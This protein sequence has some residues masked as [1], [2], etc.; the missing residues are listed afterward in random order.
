MPAYV[1]YGRA[2]PIYRK[3]TLSGD[4]GSQQ[5]ISKT[6]G[7]FVDPSGLYEIELTEETIASR[8]AI[9]PLHFRG[10]T[11]RT[12]LVAQTETIRTV[13]S[14]EETVTMT[15]SNLYSTDDLQEAVQDSLDA[16]ATANA[17]ASGIDPDGLAFVHFLSPDETY[18]KRKI[19]VSI[20]IFVGG[21]SLTSVPS[22]PT[23]LFVTPGG[24]VTV[25]VRWR[26]RTVLLTTG[27]V[28]TSLQSTTATLTASPGYEV[29]LKQGLPAP[30]PTPITLTFTA[31]ENTAI[32]IDQVSVDPSPLVCQPR[33]SL[34]PPPEG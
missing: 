20:K 24:S 12:E 14:G 29:I 1:F 25:T 2:V 6:S 23:G 18:L 15:L 13:K 27:S 32:Y 3:E 4:R 33:F 10:A 22:Y 11:K 9:S 16:Q 7:T 21:A 5:F 28:S 30:G 19:P 17:P 31:A 26:R 34:E 8:I